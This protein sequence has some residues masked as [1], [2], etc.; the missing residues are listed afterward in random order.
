MKIDSFRLYKQVDGV[1]RLEGGAGGG[2]PKGAPQAVHGVGVGGGFA[3]NAGKPVRLAHE[4]NYVDGA[5]QCVAVLRAADLLRLAAT[6]DDDAAGDGERHPLLLA[7]QELV[8]EAPLGYLEVHEF[9]DLVHSCP[10]LY[11]ALASEL[12]V[13]GDYV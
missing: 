13:V 12:Q 3:Y 4:A 1:D 7:A 5:G 11:G 2:Y 8:L 9:D 6:L 10:H